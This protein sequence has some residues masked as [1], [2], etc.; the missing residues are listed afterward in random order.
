MELWWGL[1]TVEL[2]FF[3]VSG[4][5][6]LAWRGIRINPFA[7]QGLVSFCVDSDGL[8]DPPPPTPQEQKFMFGLC[9]K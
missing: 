4:R 8:K 7:E 9:V 3:M 6:L 1:I 2:Y 5:V